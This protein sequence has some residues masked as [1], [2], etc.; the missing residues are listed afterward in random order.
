MNFVL[1]VAGEGGFSVSA[2]VGDLCPDCAM[3]DLRLPVTAIAA[4]TGGGIGIGDGSVD[5]VWSFVD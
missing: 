5:V 4:L 3:N 1:T 2:V